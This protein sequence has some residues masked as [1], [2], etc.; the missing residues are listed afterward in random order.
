MDKLPFNFTSVPSTWELCFNKDCTHKDTCMHYFAG[1]HLPADKMTGF[2][3]YPNALQNG[4]CRFY[5]KKRV[6]RAAWGFRKLFLNVKNV[7]DTPRHPTK[8][9]QSGHLLSLHERTTHPYARATRGH[10]KH[11]SCV[12]LHRRIGLRQLH[13]PLCV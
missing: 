1:Q 7:D 10:S 6:I 12:W 9:R 11:L 13:R 8:F 5:V 4:K 2:A 3:V